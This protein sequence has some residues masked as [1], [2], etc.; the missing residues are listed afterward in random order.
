MLQEEENDPVISEKIV[1]NVSYD[2]EEWEPSINHGC[3]N[4][5]FLQKC[6]ED[7]F[8]KKMKISNEDYSR[9]DFKLD[10]K[11]ILVNIFDELKG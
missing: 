2:L 4:V 6:Y 8:S 7:L 3:N 11:A 5:E 10:E 1:R 9:Y